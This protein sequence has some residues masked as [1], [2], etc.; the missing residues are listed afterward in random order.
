[1]GIPEVI[2]I[3]S[4]LSTALTVGEKLYNFSA[5]LIKKSR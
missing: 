5:L 3:L 1:M 4:G 2:L